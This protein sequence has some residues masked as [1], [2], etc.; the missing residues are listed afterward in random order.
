MSIPTSSDLA[1]AR[2]VLNSIL[3]EHSPAHSLLISLRG[4]HVFPKTNKSRANV[5]FTR[6]DASKIETIAI[7]QFADAV[8][9]EFV[10]SGLLLNEKR[11]HRRSS[12]SC[13]QGPTAPPEG[14]EEEIDPVVL[15]A[16]ILNTV[17]AI[18]RARSSQ[19]LPQRPSFNA[20]ALLKKYKNVEFLHATRIP[21]LEICKMG[22]LTEEN[23]GG[24]ECVAFIDLP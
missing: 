21:R 20:A 24:Y 3:C 4:L 9:R 7:Q 8:K 16:T 10:N 11:G 5:V 23:G 17:Y 13:Q 15:H 14:D 2:E 19:Q 6:P 12:Q 18:P 22:E 1:R